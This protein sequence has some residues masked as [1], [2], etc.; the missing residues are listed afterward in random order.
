MQLHIN[1]QHI[2]NQ[3]ATDFLED[4]KDVSENNMD[5]VESKCIKIIKLTT[6]VT[7]WGDYRW[8]G[9]NNVN[10]QVDLFVY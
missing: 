4:I 6:N 9:W 2:S 7:K 3:R 5:N 1:E 10:L 8:R